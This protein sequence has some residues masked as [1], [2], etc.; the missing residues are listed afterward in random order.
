[1]ALKDGFRNLDQ[2]PDKRVFRDCWEQQSSG[3][4]AGTRTQDPRLKRPLLY[5]LSYRPVVEDSSLRLP[6]PLRQP[7][8]FQAPWT[9]DAPPPTGESLRPINGNYSR[10]PPSQATLRTRARCRPVCEPLAL[11]TCSGVPWTTIS[12]PRSPPSGP[13]SIT[14][15]ADLMMSRLCSM[16]SRVAP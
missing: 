1:M 12:P 4:T 8:L 15:S 16:T 6:S 11:A 3:E 14:Q 7:E 5:Q 2:N 10:V 9:D 13:R